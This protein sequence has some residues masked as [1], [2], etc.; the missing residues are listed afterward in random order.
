MIKKIEAKK[1]LSRETA[2]I[3]S[4]TNYAS[5]TAKGATEI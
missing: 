3:F 5:A 1:K 2:Y 4:E